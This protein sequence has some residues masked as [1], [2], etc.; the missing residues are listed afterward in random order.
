MTTPTY[1]PG[2]EI[3]APISADFAAI[4]TPE[5]IITNNDRGGYTVTFEFE[6]TLQ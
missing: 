2:I 6:G 5:A 1:G 3:T 4:L